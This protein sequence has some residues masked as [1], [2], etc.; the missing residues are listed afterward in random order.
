MII[1]K[2]YSP[3]I[4]FW[5]E[6]INTSCYTTNTVFLRPGTK[7]ASYELWTDRKLNLKYFRTFGNKCYILRDGENLGK[8][9]S[10]SYISIFLGYSNKSKAYRVYNKKLTSYQRILEC[11]YK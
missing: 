10:K 4:Q 5:V 3:P 6:A 1:V 7:K 11:S 9:G 2:H 8:F